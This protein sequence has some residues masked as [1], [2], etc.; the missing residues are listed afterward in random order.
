MKLIFNSIQSQRPLVFT[1]L[2][3]SLR[4]SSRSVKTKNIVVNI[5]V[6]SKIRE[7]IKTGLM[8]ISDRIHESNLSSKK[9]IAEVFAKIEQNEMIE[10]IF[11]V[12]M[13]GI[14]GYVMYPLLSL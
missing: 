14:T 11:W 13:V 4:G 1:I 3:A 5:K 8:N 7:E 9:D 6:N 12:G 10:G 2:K